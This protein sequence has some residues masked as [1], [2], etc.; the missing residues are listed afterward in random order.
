MIIQLTYPDTITPGSQ[1]VLVFPIVRAQIQLAADLS[2]TIANTTITGST[3]GALTWLAT[4]DDETGT[5]AGPPDALSTLTA[6]TVLSGHGIIGFD[7]CEP[8]TGQTSNLT[9]TLSTDGGSFAA[10]TGTLSEIGTTGYYK[11]IPAIT[12]TA[13]PSLQQSS[14]TG[15]LVFRFKPTNPRAL[16]ATNT[17]IYESALYVRVRPVGLPLVNVSPGGANQFEAGGPIMGPIV[18]DLKNFI[19][20]ALRDLLGN[21]L[22]T[23][24]TFRKD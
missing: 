18:T 5:P 14:N 4:S 12:E 17:W 1:P 23:K 3:E 2:S 21:Q 24:P 11:Y 7:Q 15:L 13:T 20:A 10:C 22:T 9:A 19:R 6:I 16:A 8:I